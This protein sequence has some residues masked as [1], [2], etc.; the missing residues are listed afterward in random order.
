V[1]LR[2]VSVVLKITTDASYRHGRA[3]GC[4]HIE[5]MGTGRT[6]ERE[7]QFSCAS[8]LIAEIGTIAYALGYAPPDAAVTVMTDSEQ[9]VL[10][11]S[12]RTHTK[13][14]PTLLAVVACRNATFRNRLRMTYI[15]LSRRTRE[16]ARVDSVGRQRMRGGV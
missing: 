16:I 10:L 1:K 5:N 14:S 12:G 11:L 4:A 7:T 9:A 13:S 2:P 3:F 15:W 6:D 8:P